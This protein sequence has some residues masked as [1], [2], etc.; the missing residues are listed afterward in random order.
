M[1]LHAACTPAGVQLE[2]R[3]VQVLERPPMADVP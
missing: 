2:H 1:Y 3:H